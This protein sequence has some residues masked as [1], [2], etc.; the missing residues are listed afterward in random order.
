MLEYFFRV[1]R[2]FSFDKEE[3]RYIFAISLVFAFSIGYGRLLES[4]SAFS[5]L[6]IIL[7]SFMIAATA[8]L[9]K[10]TGHK[11]MAIKRGYTV[12]M[13]LLPH[14][15]LIALFLSI[16]LEGEIYVVL[17]V[18]GLLIHHHEKMRIGEFR[19]GHNYLDNAVI[20]LFGP[21][22]NIYL[23]LLFRLFST[24]A[25]PNV[26]IAM[27]FNIMYA[28]MG[29]VPLDILLFFFR[30]SK[31][32]E[33]ADTKEHPAP[34][35]GTYL[36]YSTKIFYASCAAIVGVLAASIYVY[37]PIISTVSALIM[38]LAAYLVLWWYN[39]FS[40]V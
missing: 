14:M 6:S 29:L 38:G 37:G 18:T 1:R 23:A 7:S 30:S 11:L 12:K 4:Q 24:L 17:P 5:A 9:T 39:D 21:L 26:V 28:V 36:L 3:L 34:V 25:N 32:L 27:E 31:A 15:L 20:A 19:Y 33:D 2:H 35:S 13:K 10:E 16:I 8:V 22:A 40:V